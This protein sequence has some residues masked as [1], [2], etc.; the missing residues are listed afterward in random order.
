MTEMELQRPRQLW[1]G[2]K[3]DRVKGRQFNLGSKRMN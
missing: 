3:E 2:I 1:K